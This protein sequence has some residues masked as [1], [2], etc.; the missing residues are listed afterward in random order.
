MYIGSRVVVRVLAAL[1]A[2]MLHC[3]NVGAVPVSALPANE[4][5]FLVQHHWPA[6]QWVEPTPFV[7]SGLGGLDEQP[8]LEEPMP[9][10]A[11]PSD[12]AA[13]LLALWI[14]LAAAADR[15]NRADQSGLLEVEMPALLAD[16]TASRRQLAAPAPSVRNADMRGVAP[17]ATVGTTAWDVGSVSLAVAPLPARASFDSSVSA[18]NPGAHQN[19]MSMDQPLPLR[20][21]QVMPWIGL[22][23]ALLAI[24]WIGWRTAG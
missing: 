5:T 13:R 2:A 17:A 23:L 20:S 16:D 19:A 10:Q 4:Q 7:I 3:A 6:A 12:R 18:G 14:R 22:A 11:D 21:I 15:A 24:G 9:A 1:A 8:S